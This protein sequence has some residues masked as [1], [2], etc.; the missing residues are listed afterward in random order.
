M[1]GNKSRLARG[2]GL[3]AWSVAMV[4]VGAIIGQVGPVAPYAEAAG[5]AMAVVELDDGK[6]AG[7]GLGEFGP[8]S[9]LSDFDA[10]G[11]TFYQSADGNLSIGVW[12]ATPGVLNVPDPYVVDELMYVLEG[13]IVLTDVDGNVSTH[14][15]G[16]GVVLPKGWTGTFAVPDGVRKIYVTYAAE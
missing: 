12:E 11:H 15:P 1:Y 5:R 2:L 13:E 9:K 6:L 10:R 7:E 4:T 16:D 8:Y 3:V 14:G